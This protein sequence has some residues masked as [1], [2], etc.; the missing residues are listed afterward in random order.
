M[1]LANEGLNEEVRADSILAKLDSAD[2]AAAAVGANDAPPPVADAAPADP[3]PDD[4]LAA[5]QA[6]D[7]APAL[8]QPSG[9]DAPA[10]DPAPEPPIS[11]P[12]SWSKEWKEKFQSL[13]RDVQ[14]VVADR[15]R[16]RDVELRRGQNEAADTRRAA[17]AAQQAANARAQE[18]V[19]EQQRYAQQLAV[20]AQQME[21]ND[22]VIAA[23]R[24]TDLQRLARDNPAQ[25]TE[26][27]AAY[28]QR[29]RQLDAV[30]TEQQRVQGESMRAWLQREQTALIAAVPEW[31][32]ATKRQA[33]LTELRNTM[34]TSYG[35]KPEEIEAVADH[36][37]V[38]VLRDAMEA[39]KL[40]AELAALKAKEAEREKVVKQAI[41]EKKVAPAAVRTLKP[42]PASDNSRSQ[43]DRS[44]ALI[45]RA[46]KARTLAEK[47]EILAQLD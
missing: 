26:L 3:A 38:R 24:N 15:E 1:S 23:Y 43:A 37:H 41:S 11:A 36:R 18:A 45:N 25:Y 17:E 6:A 16:E 5:P 12:A 7:T 4:G 29:T 30:R 31:S 20:V 21:A 28:T 34:A 46:G 47:A 13:P 35:Y 33:D 44:K 9:D 2:A 14:Q 39:P 10:P 42:G 22:P 40:R 32:D 27:H 8:A 19:Q